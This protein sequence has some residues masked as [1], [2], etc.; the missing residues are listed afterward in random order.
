VAEEA[1]G[2]EAGR[3]PD[4]VFI[5]GRA[6]TSSG[7][8]SVGLA[9]PESW[10]VNLWKGGEGEG[11]PRGEIAVGVWNDSR[12]GRADVKLRWIAGVA[13]ARRER[14][15]AERRRNIVGLMVLD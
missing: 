3:I 10:N 1:R 15:M 13:P 9:S 12:R 7:G 8:F 2:I 11:K 4:S 14:A 5:F 6:G